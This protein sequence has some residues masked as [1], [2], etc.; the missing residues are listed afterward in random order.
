MIEPALRNSIPANVTLE[1]VRRDAFDGPEDPFRVFDHIW[2]DIWPMIDMDNLEQMCKLRSLY[3]PYC[4]GSQSCW[5]EEY[6]L[7]QKIRIEQLFNILS[8]RIG[9]YI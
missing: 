9:D 2:H 6:L 4:A 5:A 3:E 1:I 7:I 8:V